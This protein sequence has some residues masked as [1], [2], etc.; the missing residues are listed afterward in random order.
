MCPTLVPVQNITAF[1]ASVALLPAAERLPSAVALEVVPLPVGSSPLFP[2]PAAATPAG[3]SAA[4]PSMPAARSQLARRTASRR[5]W[6]RGERCV[7]MVPDPRAVVEEDDGPV[8][9]RRSA[10]GE[11]STKALVLVYFF[12]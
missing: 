3:V 9:D 5:S 1:W 6:R 2:G 11:S 8:A 12:W 4:T 10:R 7:V